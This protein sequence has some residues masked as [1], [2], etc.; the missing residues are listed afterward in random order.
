RYREPGVLQGHPERGALHHAVVGERPALRRGHQPR[1]RLRRDLSP[2][3]QARAVTVTRTVPAPVVRSSRSVE[4]G[5]ELTR[6]GPVTFTAYPFGYCIG[7]TKTSVGASIV[8][9]VR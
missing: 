2:D 7:G 6:A 4:S 9:F 5:V 3:V 1:H 8:G